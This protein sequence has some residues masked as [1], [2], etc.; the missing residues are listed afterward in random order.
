MKDVELRIPWL[1]AASPSITMLFLATLGPGCAC[2]ALNQILFFR[3]G[4][5]TSGRPEPAGLWGG[6][7]RKVSAVFINNT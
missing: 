1:A 4:L 3:N 7:R 5:I 6:F 2:S